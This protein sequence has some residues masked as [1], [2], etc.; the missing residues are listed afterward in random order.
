MQNMISQIT[1]YEMLNEP[2]W[3]WFLFVGAMMLFTFAWH[4]IIEFIK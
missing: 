2:M 1:G 4:G 3:Q